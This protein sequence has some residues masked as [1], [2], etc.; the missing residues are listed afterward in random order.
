MPIKRQ[1]DATKIRVGDGGRLMPDVPVA[2]A[3]L[4]NYVVKENWR[5]EGNGNTAEEVKREGWD[6]F[7]PNSGG[8]AVNQ[9]T[10]AASAVQQIGEA[11]R[12]N[13]K[14]VP[15]AVC[16]N[17]Q[18]YWF[19][20]DSSVWTQIGSGYSSPPTGRRWE[21]VA[22]GSYAVFNNGIDLPFTW[23]VGDAVVSP[24]H[25]LRERGVASVGTIWEANQIL[26]CADILEITPSYMTTLMN[27]AG[28]YSQFTNASYTQRVQSRKIW[29]NNGDPRDF[30][31]TV[32]GSVSATSSTVTLAW[33]M[34]SLTNGTEIVLL[35]AGTDGGNLT[36]TISAGGG[37]AS[38]T[39]STPAVTTITSHPVQRSTAID[40]IVGS[41]D[42]D[43]DG[44]QVL[45]GLKLQ[46]RTVVYKPT[47][48]FVGYYT[49]DINEPWVY[50]NVY[51]GK[52]TPRYRWT[53]VNVSGG[54]H[55]FAGDERFYAFKLGLQEPVEDRVIGDAEKTLFYDL[56]GDAGQAGGAPTEDE[57]F[58][59]DNGC[60]NE[61]FI[62]FRYG[63]GMKLIAY[64]YAYGVVDPI[65]TTDNFTCFATVHKPAAGST[66]S[67]RELW[68]IMGD[69][70]GL[71]T[72]YGKTNLAIVTQQRY[73]V[74]FTSLWQTGIGDFGDGLSEK[75]VRSWVLLNSAEASGNTMTFKLYGCNRNN[76][77]P[78]L[79][80]TKTISN[81]SETPTLVPLFYRKT[82][83]AERLE[84]AVNER[85]RISGRI[86][87]VARVDSRG[88]TRISS[89]TD[90]T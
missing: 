80:E 48:I 22:V 73:Q 24:I 71:V 29:S 82:F 57:V 44:S 55:L 5:R 88:M 35:G 3:G 77:T 18:I 61:I 63:S 58:A 69:G 68:F 83:F 78:A 15:V 43:N 67:E 50:E 45:R 53:L 26:C 23:L 13:G 56:V 25:E 64:N 79:L 60:T 20:Y 49:G 70:S 86:W 75:D 42:F 14:T 51:T 81:N 17:G 2:E 40:S 72:Q 11:R 89:P 62:R 66:A 59:A 65:V 27:G 8:S 10:I 74:S 1:Y 84:T 76:Q 87:E 52:R 7:K 9:K 38:L 37:T 36:A 30:A 31:A 33:P 28:A 32:N 19:N 16:A 54:Y 4:A 90:A 6:W 12:P 47:S 41:Y 21:I 85:L 46:N 39:I 34:T